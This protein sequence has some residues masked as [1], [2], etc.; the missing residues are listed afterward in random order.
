MRNAF[1]LAIK[2]LSVLKISEFLSW[3]YGHVRKQLDYIKKVTFKI[4][5]VLTWKSNITLLP[6]I[7]R[8]KASQATKFGQLIGYNVETYV[9]YI[10]LRSIEIYW[11][12]ASNQ[13][14]SA[15][16]KLFQKTKIG[17]ELVSLSYSLRGFWRK[18]L[19]GYIILTDQV[20]LSGCLYF[21][22]YW[23]CVL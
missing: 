21:V 9:T 11:K 14:L 15:L 12:Q 20:S 4:Y 2:A 10:K 3:L 13:I 18:K 19:S 23:V 1:Y 7:P 5:D 17:L 22:R 8:R 16:R 6:Y